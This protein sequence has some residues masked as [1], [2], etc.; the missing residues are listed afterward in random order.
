MS[1]SNKGH[2]PRRMLSSGFTLAV[3]VGGIIGLGILRTPG[4][5]AAVVPDPL[6][7]VSL[8]V[9]GGLFILLSTVVAAELMGMTPRSGGI[10][11]LV[12]R[13]Y[14]PFP[15]FVIGLLS[16]QWKYEPGEADLTVMRLVISGEED[17]RSTTYTY[18]L[19]DEYDP[20]TGVLSM[21]RTTGYT[22]TAVA[23]LVL[24]G[25]YSQKGISPP[26]FVGRIDGCW[27]RVEKYLE[28]RGVRCRLQRRLG[29]RS[30]H[31]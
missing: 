24:D 25:G 1:S 6:M 3:T 23:R 18:D 21:A 20:E 10:Y 2:H 14:G 4:E 29:S 8:W 11:A 17:G 26:E 5:V 28:D 16:P 13:A 27:E 9:L 15:G 31:V 12:R 30:E 22:C 19:Y 7:F